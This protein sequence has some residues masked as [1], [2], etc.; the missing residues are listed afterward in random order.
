MH[1]YR[2]FSVSTDKIVHWNLPHNPVDLEQ[3]EGRINRY[4]CLSI[5]QSLAQKYGNA[6]FTSDVWDEVFQFALDAKGKDEPE[7]VPFWCLP[8]GSVKIERIIP[9]YPYS[10]DKAIYNRL[11]KILSLYR[12]T[13]GQARQEEL[14]EYLFNNRSSEE[15]KELFIN[16]SPIRRE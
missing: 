15:L 4:K 8:D 7:L 1:G 16:L 9:M 12:V 14:L 5:R 3:R 13:M 10:K 6:D 2:S 11:L